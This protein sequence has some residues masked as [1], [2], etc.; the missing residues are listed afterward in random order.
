M[1]AISPTAGSRSSIRGA[2]HNGGCGEGRRRAGASLIT[3]AN[4]AA[5][6]CLRSGILAAG[7]GWRRPRR[8]RG[9]VRCWPR[10]IRTNTNKQRYGCG[11]SVPLPWMSSRF[12]RRRVPGP[13][14]R[15]WEVCVSTPSPRFRR[16]GA[17]VSVRPGFGVGSRDQAQHF[18]DPL[19]SRFSLVGKLISV[20]AETSCQ[21]WL[22]G[23]NLDP[24]GSGTHQ[25]EVQ[26]WLYIYLWLAPFWQA[27]AELLWQALGSLPHLRHRYSSQLPLLQSP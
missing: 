18:R 11:P 7:P 6:M 21:P 25:G 15:C 16:E 13:T 3:R 17:P 1:S 5:A 24:A 22:R 4:F 9:G 12:R 26:K 10:T 2:K 23:G 20:S 14:A 27:L 19:V 8:W